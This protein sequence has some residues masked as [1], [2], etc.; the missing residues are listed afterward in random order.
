MWRMLAVTAMIAG[1]IGFLGCG[2]G[3]PSSKTPVLALVSVQCDK[4][5]ADAYPTVGC[6]GEVKNL[7]SALVGD[8]L[9]QVVSLD[10]NGKVLSTSQQQLMEAPIPPGQARRWTAVT[11]YVEGTRDYRI[12]F[13]DTGGSKLETVDQSGQ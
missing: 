7:T 11:D 2:T 8:L 12:E 4:S 1:V 9:V 10:S 13:F 3:K 5:V 6:Y